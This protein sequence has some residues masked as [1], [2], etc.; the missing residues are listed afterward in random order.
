MT[1]PRRSAQEVFTD[2][3][4]EGK[5]GSVED[6]LARNYAA[7]VVVLSG[8][9][10]HRGHEGV[11]ELAKLLREELL[12]AEFDYRTVLLEGDVG[13]LEW[14]GR[15]EQAVVED[16]ADSFLIRDGLIITQTIHYTVQARKEA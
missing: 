7:D 13:F 8:R 14:T 4:H 15:S 12:D 2:H 16:G 3:L 6:D 11:R 1:T 10:V 5:Y 9:G